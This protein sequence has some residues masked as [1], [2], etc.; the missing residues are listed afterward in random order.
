MASATLTPS[1]LLLPTIK[2]EPGRIYAARLKAGGSR[3]VEVGCLLVG[4]LFWNGI[5]SIFLLE[6]VRGWLSGRG[7]LLLTLF[8]IPF[9]L[10]GIGLL[11][12]L[13]RS[14]LLAIRVRETILEIEKTILVPGERVP[15][16]VAQHG[17]LPLNNF[18]VSLVCEE[19][20]T[21]RR[22]TDTYT[23]SNT[24][25]DQQIITTGPV[26]TTIARPLEKHFDL[27]IPADAMHSF[28]ARNNKI[29][30]KVHVKGEVA[31]WPDFAFDFILCVVPPDPHRRF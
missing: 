13:L 14:I 9:E 15:A 10:V 4:C 5:L 1:D 2:A 16:Y 30:W 23:E 6:M 24:L 21:Y 31:R 17:A 8:L 20:I 11:V 7:D 29:V 25:L 3:T 27:A 26:T 28:E 18:I 19:K 22:G 12:F